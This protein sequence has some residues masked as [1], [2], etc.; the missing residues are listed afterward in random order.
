MIQILMVDDEPSILEISKEF[1]NRNG[2]IV[3]DAVDNATLALKKLDENVYSAI[4]SDYQMP[5]MDG[6]E[7]LKRVRSINRDIPFIIFTGK[8]REEV[9][10]EALINGANFYIMKGRDIQAQY[11]ELENAIRQA[12]VKKEAEKAVEYNMKRFRTLIENSYDI[13]AIIDPSMKFSYISPSSERILGYPSWKLAGSLVLDIVHPEDTERTSNIILESIQE[14]YSRKVFEFRA[15]C[16]DGSFRV[17]ECVINKDL[18]DPEKPHVFLNAHDI[19]GKKRMQEIQAAIYRISAATNTTGDLKELFQEIHSIVGELMFVENFYISLIDP[20]RNVLTFPY[21]VDQCDEAPPHAKSDEGLTGYVFRTGLPILIS[22]EKFEELVERGEM[23]RLGTASVDYMGVPLKV[24]GRQIGVMAIQ[25]YSEQVRFTEKDMEILSFVSDQVAMAIERKRAEEELRKSEERLYQIIEN[26][27][28]PTFVIDSDHTVIH[29]N[30]AC[31]KLTRI[32]AEEIVGT[33]KQWS[34]FYLVERPVMADLI[35]DQASEEEVKR[36]YANKYERSTQM[37]EAY[38]AEDFF[39]DFG[40]EG[41][42]LFFTAAPMRDSKGNILGAI[43]TLQD[44]TKRWRAEKSLKESESEYRT[45]FENTG[46]ATVIIE[47]DTTISM[48]NT[49]FE[50]ISGYTKE[51]LEGAISWTKFVSREDLMRMREYHDHRRMDQGGPPHKYEFH[52]IHKDGSIREASASVTMFP[53]TKRSIA[54]LMDISE[55]KRAE[56]ALKRESEDRRI[57]LD[58]IETQ[59]WYATNPETLGAV[60]RARA[61]FLGRMKGEL[62]GMRLCDILG[63]KETKTCIESNREAFQ[64]RKVQR[65]EWLR[66]S[67]GDSRCV[68]VTKIPKLDENGNVEYIVCTGQDITGRKKNEEDLRIANKKLNLLGGITGHD[69]LNQLTVIMAYSELLKSSIEDEKLLK[70][71]DNIGKSGESVKEMIAFR[72][73]YERIVARESEWVKVAE[74]IDRVASKLP[75]GE[76]SLKVNLD[77]LEIYSDPLIGK[78]F[79]NLLQNSL[80][81]GGDLSEIVVDFRKEENG[82]ALIFKDDGAGIPEIEKDKIFDYGYGKHLGYGLHHIREILEIY[83]MNIKEIGTPG[84]GA[85]F[86][87]WITP[88]HYRLQG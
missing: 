33:K 10:T 67:K 27:T 55:R 73:E 30:K 42:W 77:S 59:I 70:Y 46:M 4:V 14:P 61:Q 36:Y 23:N 34:A 63:E 47:E 68:L 18:E 3:I 65:E 85:E 88:S 26:C 8:G 22:S 44:V 86:E 49:E 71:L 35:V 5:G 24:E 52:F 64:G 16:D 83:D 78:V 87:I 51:D 57:L 54:S 15:I 40:E 7:F 75:F 81:H 6:I 84:E 29:W 72:R 43:E 12:V 41:K 25:S 17:L 28:I 62:E 80:H 19:T 32:P 20:V 13:I 74:T 66:T 60:N 1:L 2:D 45:I 69:V 79:Y 56:E 11:V 39:P 9:A 31:E 53:G 58:N 76:V 48:A 82:V 37:K 38:E 21:F 50:E